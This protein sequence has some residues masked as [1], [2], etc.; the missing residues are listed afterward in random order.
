MN[1]AEFLHTLGK[2][3]QVLNEKERA[4]ILNEYSQHI[5]MRVESGMSEEETIKDFGDFDELV[6]EILEAYNLNPNFNRSHIDSE[7]ITRK[8]SGIFSN[9]G[10]ILG[11]TLER[12]N[13][14]IKSIPYKNPSFL[15]KFTLLVFGIFVLYVFSTAVIFHMSDFISEIFPYYMSGI[16]WFVVFIVFNIMFIILSVTILYAYTSN[17]KEKSEACENGEGSVNKIKLPKI[18]VSKIKLKKEEC[19]EKRE[20]RK[21]ELHLIEKILGFLIFMLKLFVIFFFLLPIAGMLFFAVIGLGLLVVMCFMGYPVIGIAMI[22]LGAVVC[23]VT[24]I[25]F[26]WDLIMKNREA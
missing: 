15:I 6:S 20:G 8:V 10:S 7:E 12:L 19:A 9:L 3:L 25:W 13:L 18:D 1:K 11:D 14:L 21:M 17:A 24:F 16:V 5:D 2:R 22:D 4:D 23:G 26:V